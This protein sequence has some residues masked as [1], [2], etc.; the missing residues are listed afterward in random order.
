MQCN[1]VDNNN[2]IMTEDVIGNK[3]PTSGGQHPVRVKKDNKQAKHEG[4]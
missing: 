1:N 2:M 3:V 4:Y